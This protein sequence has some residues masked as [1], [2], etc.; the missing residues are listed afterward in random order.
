M[1]MVRNLR[2]KEDRIRSRLNMI[3]DWQTKNN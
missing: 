3:H 2:E 1:V